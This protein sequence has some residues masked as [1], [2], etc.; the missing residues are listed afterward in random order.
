MNRSHR[1]IGSRPLSWG[2]GIL[3]LLALIPATIP[4]AAG[5]PRIGQPPRESVARTPLR[6]LDGQELTLQELRGEVVV[7]N[8]FAIWC[9]HSKHHVS[10]LTKYGENERSRGLRILGLAVKDSE[11]TPDRLQ[12]FIRDYN[13]TYPV[14]SVTD[15]LF[16]R[17]IESSDVSVPQTLV[18]GRDGRLAAHFQGHDATVESRMRATIAAELA[19]Q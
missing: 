9:G 8:F 6:M 12:R 13:I 14:G 1:S 19:K 4:T 11:S 7:V 15:A 17:F 5:M 16:T 18:Y 2:L 3:F 10:S